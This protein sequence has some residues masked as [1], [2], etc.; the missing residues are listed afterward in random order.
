MFQLFVY[1]CFVGSA[2][3]TA[4]AAAAPV[5]AD[6]GRDGLADVVPDDGAAV[7]AAVDGARLADGGR[8]AALVVGTTDIP[9]VATGGASPSRGTN[10]NRNTASLFGAPFFISFNSRY[11]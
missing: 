7:A 8:D 2:A 11:G 6:D 10:D 5:A 1:G 9:R 3:G 4:T